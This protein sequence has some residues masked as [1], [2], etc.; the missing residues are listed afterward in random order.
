[1]TASDQ[2]NHYCHPW[3]DCNHQ[4]HCLQW[5]RII[6]MNQHHPQQLLTQLYARMQSLN[7]CKITRI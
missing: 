2:G 1:M 7:N 4:Q 6:A 3:I 5:P